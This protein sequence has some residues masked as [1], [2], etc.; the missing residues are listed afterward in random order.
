MLKFGKK[1]MRLISSLI[2]IMLLFSCNKDKFSDEPKITFKEFDRAEG[3]TQDF[4]GSAPHIIIEVTD[5]N[6]DLGLIPNKDTALVFIKNLL[7]NKLDSFPFPNIG[8]SGT[9]NLKCEVKVSLLE[10]MPGR[11]LP[12]SQR[13][14]MDTIFFEVYVTDFAKNKSNVIITD[15]PFVFY[16][17]P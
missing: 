9:K 4:V 3:S 11:S 7:T 5:G 12:T 10:T 14:Y 6:G 16:T 15:K 1:N 8:S 2:L 17:L 13:P